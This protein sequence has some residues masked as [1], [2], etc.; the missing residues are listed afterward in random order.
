MSCS[1]VSFE[2]LILLVYSMCVYV[3]MLYIPF[4]ECF[5]WSYVGGV[6]ACVLPNSVDRGGGV[7]R[8]GVC[9]V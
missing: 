1:V 2:F 6:R 3:G 5:V 7:F 8:I 4:R 9:R